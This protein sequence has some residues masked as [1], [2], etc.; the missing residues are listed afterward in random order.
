VDELPHKLKLEL[1]LYI[2]EQTYRRIDLFRG[3]TSAFIAWICPL[4]K[5]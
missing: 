4:L 3:R 2:H 5:P 1:S